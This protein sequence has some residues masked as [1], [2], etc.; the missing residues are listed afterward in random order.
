MVK[1]IMPIVVSVF[2]SLVLASCG[3]TNKPIADN[4]GRDTVEQEKETA[5]ETETIYSYRELEQMDEITIEDDKIILVLY[6]NQAIPYRWDSSTNSSVLSL[7]AD[8]VVYGEGDFFSAGVSPA[9]H[10]F[11]YQW[12]CDGEANVELIHKRYESDDRKEAN[13]IRT[14]Y[15][16]KTDVNVTCEEI[17]REYPE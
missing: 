16:R 17:N 6:E 4:A 11:I 15:A 1:G 9:Y 8:E 3:T 2:V 12:S 5:L 13:E 14:L 10:A 7:I